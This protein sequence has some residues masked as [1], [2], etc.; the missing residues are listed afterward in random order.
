[1]RLISNFKDYYDCMQRYDEDR[2][3]VYIRN[4]K[5]V[6]DY[7]TKWSNGLY[8]GYNR[9]F[10]GFCGKLYYG[11]LRVDYGNKII[12][13]IWNPEKIDEIILSLIGDRKKNPNH[14]FRI[15][16]W[17]DNSLKKN[18]ELLKKP[19]YQSCVWADYGNKIIHH[20]HLRSIFFQKAV[21][22]QQ[23]WIELSNWWNN[24]ARP[25]KEAPPI[26]D[27]TMAEIKG[28]N[29]FSF[30]KDPSKRK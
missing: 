4:T 30:R 26:D 28:F 20:P 22:P 15:P 23:A 24:Q 27:K 25:I 3:T 1:M 17:Y 21:P 7:S 29:K 14:Y 8:V 5:I 10:V 6:S 19:L 2:D 11:L 18:Q 13:G 9:C 16:N 12:D